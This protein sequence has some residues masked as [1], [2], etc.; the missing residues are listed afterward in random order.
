MVLTEKWLALFISVQKK[1]L[2]LSINHFLLDFINE[3]SVLARKSCHK[4]LFASGILNVD[5]TSCF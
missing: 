1:K 5:Q 4:K 2:M 3:D